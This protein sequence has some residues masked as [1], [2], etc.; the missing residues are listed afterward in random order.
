M[1]HFS[2]HRGHSFSLIHTPSG[3]AVARV[4]RAD[5]WWEQG[6][7][8]LGLSSLAPGEGLW[9]PG[10]SSV[11]TLFVRFSL[12]LLFLDGDFRQIC[13]RPRVPPWRPVVWA[14]GAHHTVELGAG[15]LARLPG[16]AATGDAWEL[17]AA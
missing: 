15:T 6:R 5:G 2:T 14:P 1:S 7:G 4:V 11:H 17:Q 9:L 10:V 8:V 16:S 12:D 13:A 3:Q